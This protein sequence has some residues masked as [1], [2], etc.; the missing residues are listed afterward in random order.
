MYSNFRL[1]IAG[2]LPGIGSQG[3]PDVENHFVAVPSWVMRKALFKFLEQDIV[4]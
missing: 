1:V 3:N 4:R 2:D